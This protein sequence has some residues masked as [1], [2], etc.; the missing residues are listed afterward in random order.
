MTIERGLEDISNLNYAEATEEKTI[1][2]KDGNE[3]TE[4]KIWASAYG[5]GGSMSRFGVMTDFK[6]FEAVHSYA[7][8]N[9]V[10][11]SELNI[12][13]EVVDVPKIQVD[14]NIYNMGNV[15]LGDTVVVNVLSDPLFSFINGSYRVYK[16]ETDI[17]IDSVETMKLTLTP[18]DKAALQIISFP[19]DYKYLK[20]DLKRLST[21]ANR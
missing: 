4:K 1:K 9:D 20:N 6:N 14:S 2:D 15:F 12:F 21:G 5:S 13:D 10:G 3:Q 16:F 11:G 18:P 7:D 8:L 17:S 19:K